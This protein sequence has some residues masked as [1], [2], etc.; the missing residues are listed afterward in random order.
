MR[1]RS[2]RQPPFLRDVPSVANDCTDKEPFVDKPR[3]EV[4]IEEVMSVASKLAHALDRLVDLQSGPPLLA[5]K[6]AWEQTMDDAE[7]AIRMFEE[8]EVGESLQ[9]AIRAWDETIRPEIDR[10]TQEQE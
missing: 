1:G 3:A 4:R 10:L 9:D 8:L 5:L 2:L 7:T 6:N